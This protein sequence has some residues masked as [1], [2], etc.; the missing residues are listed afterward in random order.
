[1]RRIAATIGLLFAGCAA[2]DI[3]EGGECEGAAC[4]PRGNAPDAAAGDAAP[5]GDAAWRSDGAPAD[6]GASDAAASDAVAPDAAPP[7]GSDR[8]RD[9]V[10]AP[11]DCDDTDGRRWPG[12]PETPDDGVDSDCDD[13]DAIPCGAIDDCPPAHYCAFDA[14]AGRCLP[15]CRAE[16]CRDGQRCHSRLRACVPDDATFSCG[17]SA[18]CPDGSICRVDAVPGTDDMIARCR[19]P[20]G[21]GARAAAC[22]EGADCASGICVTGQCLDPCL[23]DGDCLDGNTCLWTRLF[24]GSTAWR[25]RTCRQAPR[26]CERLGDCGPTERCAPIAASDGPRGFLL[27]CVPGRIGAGAGGAACARDEECV[28]G[29]CL[30]EG[31]CFGPCAADGDCAGDAR[32][33][34]AGVF[35]VDDGSTVGRADDLRIGL[36]ACLPDG[37]SAAPCARTADCEGGEVCAL[38]TSVD[39]RRLVAACVRGGEGAAAGAPCADDGAC[40]SGFCREGACFGVCGA[41]ADCAAGAR[42]AVGRYVFGT[43]GTRDPNDDVYAD[44]GLCA[45]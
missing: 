32:C 16:D 37:G 4:G 29:E 42:C 7:P 17:R 26:R 21:P 8:D 43:Q 40:A 2:G 3:A 9:G 45:R 14:D 30:D 20:E 11:E 19:E 18:D 5:V 22:D 39:G 24:N 23:A 12:A 28:T 41:D 6:A 31:I 35:I 38:R 34:E 13:F 25:I 36:P 44:V 1:M 33:Y 10:A 15:G 27:A